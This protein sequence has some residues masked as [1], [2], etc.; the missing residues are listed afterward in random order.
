MG[1]ASVETPAA[2]RRSPASSC[3]PRSRV[4]EI[5]QVLVG[6][7]RAPPLAGVAGVVQLARFSPTPPA[8]R[9][10]AFPARSLTATNGMREPADGFVMIA[11]APPASSL[12]RIVRPCT[13]TSTYDSSGDTARE[14]RPLGRTFVVVH[15]P[16]PSVDLRCPSSPHRSMIPPS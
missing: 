4:Y 12:S 5:D 13:D 16:P 9:S 7:R 15:V 6:Q 3:A 11:H 8:Q 2:N 14:Q 1:Q 10:N